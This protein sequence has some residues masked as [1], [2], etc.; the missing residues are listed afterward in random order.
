[1]TAGSHQSS[2]TLQQIKRYRERLQGNSFRPFLSKPWQQERAIRKLAADGTPDAVG[3]LADGVVA[4]CFQSAALRAEVIALLEPLLSR[5]QNV[6]IV[7]ELCRHWI[8]SGELDLPLMHLLLDAEYA[9]SEPAERA[10]FWLLS[11][12]IQRYEELDLDGSLLT[13]AHANASPTLRKRLAA[14]AAAAGRLEWLSAMEQSKP[15]EA[16]T[17]DDWATTMQ[18]LTRVGDLETLWE[19]ALKTPPI[20][21]RLLLQ[22]IPAGTAPPQQFGEGAKGLQRHAMN[23][24]ALGDQNQLPPEH[25]NQILSGHT[26][27]VRSIA[28]SPDG[29]CIASGSWDHTI[30][31]WDPASGTCTHTLTGH[32]NV[33]S[34]I[35]WS[36]DGHCLASDSY[37]HTIR[38]WDP[39]TCA[40][41]HTLSGH[42]E[43]V[44]SISWSPDGRCIAS[45]DRCIASGSWDDHSIRLWDPASG[46]CTHTLWG[47]GWRVIRIAWSPD[48][49]CLA[50]CSEDTTIR[51]W[52]PATGACTHTLSGHSREVT[53][54]AWSPDGRC[55]ASGS[56]NRPILLWDP[57]TGACTHTL[58]GHRE[59]VR[60]I[61]WSP[62]GRCLA[63]GSDDH[64]IRLWDPSTGACTHTISGHSGSVYTIAWS[65]DGRCIASG[66]G[67]KTIRLCGNEFF[68]LLTIPVASYSSEQWKLFSALQKQRIK[69]EAWQRPWL[70]FIAALSSLIRRFDV[71][72]DNQA[73]KPALSKFEIEIDG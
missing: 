41:T 49:R 11:G 56:N 65:P 10:I 15:L 50:S 52:D 24:P 22:R 37:D 40:C 1:M 5:L 27:A 46:R 57:T 39:A 59:W 8:E 61:A 14:A 2:L 58:T 34:S 7:D 62:D 21:S 64:T 53:S 73:S 69:V 51:L 42:S 19:W 29:R 16:F 60:S 55:L 63:S 38:L 26:S 48:G 43:S 72:L 33:V 18:L 54:I 3:G 28:W 45:A 66:G 13:Q 35:A 68:S 31:L 32:S 67:D 9:P 71:S 23:L 20:Y 44:W 4:N 30:R 36:P 70:E 25:C 12:K 17:E 6:A 47:H